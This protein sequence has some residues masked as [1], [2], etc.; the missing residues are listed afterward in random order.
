MR[1]RRWVRRA[2][3]PHALP[4]RRGAPPHTGPPPASVGG[5]RWV[6]GCTG[7]A[8]LAELACHTQGLARPPRR[9]APCQSRGAG[10]GPVCRKHLAG[11]C[12]S[13][14]CTSQFCAEDSAATGPGPYE[15][16]PGHRCPSP[17]GLTSQD[18]LPGEPRMGAITPA[19]ERASIHPSAPHPAAQPCAGSPHLGMARQARCTAAPSVGGGG[20]C[21]LQPRSGHRSPRGHAFQNPPRRGT[22]LLRPLAS[23]RKWR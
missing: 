11:G 2:P 8:E 19:W 12:G 5:W 14:P 17:R 6:R 20:P 23:S 13:S 16:G 22:C 9:P 10:D 3:F 21:V 18:P 15:R 1:T 7:K 4:P